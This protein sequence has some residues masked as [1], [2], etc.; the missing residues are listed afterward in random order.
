MAPYHILTLDGGGIRGLLTAIML[1]KLEKAVPGFL[2]KVDLIAGTSTGGLLALGLAVG[3][4]PEALSNL[5]LKKGKQ[6][7]DDSWIDNVLDLGNLIGAKYNLQNLERAAKQELGNKRLRDLN[8]NVLIT[9]FD[10]DNK[11]GKT[12]SEDPEPS[13]PRQWKPK[14][15]HNFKG[16]DE[17][18]LD[19]LAYKVAVY[20]SA[21]PTYFPSADGFIDGGVVANN[22]SMAGLAQALDPR[23]RFDPPASRP[24]LGDIVLLSVGTGLTLKY[25][26]SGPNNDV[27]WGQA[28]WVQPLISL[29]LDGIAGVAD[30]ECRQLLNQRYLRLAP[31]FPP[32]FKMDM[33]EVGKMKDLVK[34]AET[35]PVQTEIDKTIAWLK[36]HWI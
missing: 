13:K 36:Q 3:K 16:L 35:A 12:G 4:T 15:F 34:F 10:L 1:G 5:Y 30:Y 11:D 9:A 20:T 31:V 26:E 7:F 32:E 33:D 17:K 25:I 8:K 24:M 2:N 19:L 28:Q 27:D 6:I 22:P 14:F 23:N 29:I 21:A 18:D